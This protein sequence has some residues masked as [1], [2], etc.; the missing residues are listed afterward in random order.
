MTFNRSI[1]DSNK[2]IATILAYALVPLAG[3][4][5]DIYLPSLPGMAK[6][7]GVSENYI[8]LTLSTFLISYGIS[9]II[10]GTIVDIY[11]RFK[12]SLVCLVFF[13]ITCVVIATSHN[14][15][16]II[17]M[18][19]LQ[20]MF[21]G[22]V[23]VSK[24][25]FFVDVYEGEKL[26]NL[27]TYM[28][29]V[30][31]G[32]PI[33]APFIGGYLETY[34]GWRSNFYGLAIYA[35]IMLVLEAKYS[36]ESIKFKHELKW[37]K[38]LETYKE[39]LTT[40]DFVFAIL[41][42][43][44]CYGLVM[45]YSMSGPFIIEHNMGYTPVVTGYASLILGLSWM[46]GGMVSKQ[47]IKSA[48]KKKSIWSVGI[49][50]VL[51]IGMIVWGMTNESIY[52]MVGIAFLIHISAGFIFNIFF[53]ISLSR[54]PQYAGSSSG[55]VGGAVYFF[56]SLSS[57]LMI[58]TVNPMNEYELGW[59]YLIFA[60]FSILMLVLTNKALQKRTENA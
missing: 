8:Q 30:W 9:Q 28:T 48:P 15:N 58:S 29:I 38:I 55:L 52:H 12:T 45:T 16:V 51:A 36:G 13:V 33:L 42:L 59:S 3:L 23:V 37:Q 27:L 22:I 53:T 11:G 6:D 1:T 25:V 5:T 54:F 10:S 50:T 31:A 32:A 26:K 57:Y 4:I 44:S 20:G 56:T 18:R 49:Q 46:L 7:L 40:K 19:V 17:A 47:L 41:L 24:R 60:L 14:I 39:M 21:A 2:K 35:F 34:W 43:G